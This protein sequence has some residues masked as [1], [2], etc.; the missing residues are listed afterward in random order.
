LCAIFACDGGVGKCRTKC[1]KTNKTL[2]GPPPL[3]TPSFVAFIPKS[4]F[5]KILSLYWVL[6]VQ[7]PYWKVFVVKVKCTH[8][9]LP[10]ATF[11][12]TSVGASWVPVESDL[13][14][15]SASALLGFLGQCFIVKY[16]SEQMCSG[17]I[18]VLRRKGREE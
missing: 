13:P 11:H 2:P 18:S 17:V 5:Y 3:P 8:C 1:V 14:Y 12:L 6:P 9:L 4:V 10:M 15:S 7:F 16:N